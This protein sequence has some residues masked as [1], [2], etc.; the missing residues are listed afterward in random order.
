[1]LRNPVDMIYSLHG[2]YVRTKNDE[3]KD[4]PTALAL[5]ADRMKGLSIPQTCYFPEGLFYTEVAR[6]YEK[7]KRFA[8]VFER[9]NIHVV[10]FEDF[11]THT[12]QSYKDT[13]DFLE[14]APGFPAEFDL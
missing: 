6:Y 14:L 13:L 10:I 2:L 12:P 7:I 4:F 1:M 9:K 8:E 11:V 3:V 5:Q